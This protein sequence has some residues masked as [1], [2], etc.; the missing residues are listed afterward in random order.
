MLVP[1]YP[2]PKEIAKLAARIH[3]MLADKNQVSFGITPEGRLVTNYDEPEYLEMGTV[4]GP[5]GDGDVSILARY[6]AE[7]LRHSVV[8]VA[9]Y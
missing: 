8:P 5:A 2:T 3:L 7:R 4:R 6:V 1:H 9:P